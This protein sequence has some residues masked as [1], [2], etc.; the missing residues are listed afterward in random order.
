MWPTLVIIMEAWTLLESI[1]GPE[2]IYL[3]HW[4]AYLCVFVFLIVVM[5]VSVI[6]NYIT[7][8]YEEYKWWWRVYLAAFSTGVWLFFVAVYFFLIDTSID[9]LMTLISCITAAGLV[10]T[11]IG[12]M[13]AS[14]AMIATFRF[15]LRIYARI[16]SE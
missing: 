13:A 3:L 14:V 11:M 5:E 9:S 12:L 1:S 10:C 8:C 16:K 7:L 15:N 6:L 2:Y 4:F